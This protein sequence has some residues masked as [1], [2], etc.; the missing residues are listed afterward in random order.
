MSQMSL[1]PLVSMKL[2]KKDMFIRMSDFNSR[3]NSNESLVAMV[4]IISYMW[5][6]ITTMSNIYKKTDF[7]G[8]K[9][10]GR[11]VYKNSHKG[12]YAHVGISCY[13]KCGLWFTVWFQQVQML[14]QTL[15]LILVLVTSL[16]VT[17]TTGVESRWNERRVG[18]AHYLRVFLFR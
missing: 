7:T 2:S 14:Y 3:T 11:G 4:H 13:C 9:Q 17:K 12:A 10:S 18:L 16:S 1:A 8:C 5:T 6:N 15:Y